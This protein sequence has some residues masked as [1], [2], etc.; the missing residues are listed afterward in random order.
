MIIMSASSLGINVD[1][2]DFLAP[3]STNGSA[4]SVI[5]TRFYDNDVN[6]TELSVMSPSAS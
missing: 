1:D 6:D 5:Y 4:K 3:G 2:D